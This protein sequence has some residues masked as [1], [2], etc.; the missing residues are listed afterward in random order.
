MAFFLFSE[1]AVSGMRLTRQV[2]ALLALHIVAFKSGEM[3]VSLSDFGRM[4]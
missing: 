2:F 4:A 1:L 3:Q